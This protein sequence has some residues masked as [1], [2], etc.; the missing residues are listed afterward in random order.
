MCKKRGLIRKPITITRSEKTT[1]HTQYIN[2]S[3]VGRYMDSYIVHMQE[4]DMEEA[5]DW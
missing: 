3:T 2:L 1:A 4:I 5:E